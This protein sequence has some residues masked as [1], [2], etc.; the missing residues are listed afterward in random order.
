MPYNGSGVYSLP[1]GS[2]VADGT[3]ID[4]NDHN[5]PLL[6]IEET[7]STVALRNGAAP[8]TGN[9]VI[10]VNSVGPAL[11]I[12]QVG[13]GNALLVEDSSNPDS[14]PTVIDG[15]GNV[16]IGGLNPLSKLDVV[17][18]A[19]VFGDSRAVNTTKN[20]RP[21]V[22]S[23]AGIST[24]FTPFFAA[25]E[26][27][28]NILRIGGGTS[29]AYAATAIRF[30]TAGNATTT[31][32]TERM[33]IDANGNVGIGTIAP[34]HDLEITKAK[35]GANTE[36]LVRNTDT[37]VTSAAYAYVHQGA[38]QAF[39]GS[40]GNQIGVVGTSSAHPFILE[41]GAS[42]R[43]R[44]DASTG[45]VLV[46]YSSSNGAFKLQVNSQIFAT[47]STIATSDGRYKENVTPISG[48]LEIVSA[49]NPVQFT[50]KPHPIHNFDASGPT[51]GFIA[52]EVETALASRPY[53]NSIIKKNNCVIQ[54]EQRDE[55]GNVT[56]ERVTEEFYG[57]AEGNLIAILTKA[58]QE[59]Q[60]QINALTIRIEALENAA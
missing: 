47:S 10:S 18:V 45:N 60:T 5:T 13:A 4:A 25:C 34:S 20:W 48:A 40:F 7:L 46:G 6:D 38:V 42:E 29:A 44:L 16:I 52:Q 19:P 35:S 36:L 32:G 15:D 43:M 30:F 22:P 11:R 51:V 41:A 57:I 17:D 50:W 12:T 26:S 58:I 24:F 33:V 31:T 1:A 21:R 9:Q 56:Q 55:S 27:A 2:L 53:L 49:L 59:Q 37:S 8:F 28:A 54:P 14:T 3:T 39:F 23:F